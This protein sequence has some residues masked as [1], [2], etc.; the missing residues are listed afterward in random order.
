MPYLLGVGRG[1]EGWGVSFT[2]TSRG[3]RHPPPMGAPRIFSF[4]RLAP[5]PTGWPEFLDG[6]D[7]PDR[8]LVRMWFFCSMQYLSGAI[9]AGWALLGNYFVRTVDIWLL[10]WLLELR[11]HQPS[12][13]LS[14]QTLKQARCHVGQSLTANVMNVICNVICVKYAQK[15]YTFYN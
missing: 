13:Q 11:T 6:K 10:R 15:I 9:E 1:G 4:R 5:P 2:P 14:K 3:R 12:H 7:G 8:D